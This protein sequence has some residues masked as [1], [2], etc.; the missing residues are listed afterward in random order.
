[1]ATIKQEVSTPK[2]DVRLTES[3]ELNM[4]V[5]VLIRSTEGPNT[6][7]QLSQ[8]LANLEDEEPLAVWRDV[9]HDVSRDHGGFGYNRFA[10][11]PSRIASAW[12]SMPQG[13]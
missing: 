10:V 1:M 4:R 9:G 3:P 7:K 5:T 2:V 6:W 13:R 8:R 11:T 12:E